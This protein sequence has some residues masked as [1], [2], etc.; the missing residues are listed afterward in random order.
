MTT[1]TCIK[2]GAQIL[3]DNAYLYGDLF[4]LSHDG[5]VVAHFIKA[6][7]RA[8]S[9]EDVTRLHAQYSD[10]FLDLPLAEPLNKYFMLLPQPMW[11]DYEGRTAS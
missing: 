3:V 9:D 6:V 8:Y 5:K 4:E 7:H 11:F 2:T 1:M 10:W